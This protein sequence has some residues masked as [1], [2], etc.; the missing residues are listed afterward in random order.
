MS[1]RSL[2]EKLAKVE[3]IPLKMSCVFEPEAINRL[4]PR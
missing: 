4:N 3:M 1:E 2:R